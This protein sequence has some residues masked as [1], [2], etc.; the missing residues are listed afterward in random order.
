MGGTFYLDEITELHDELALDQ[1]PGETAEEREARAQDI[2]E[3]PR[4]RKQG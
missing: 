3:R 1:F 4:F 2:V